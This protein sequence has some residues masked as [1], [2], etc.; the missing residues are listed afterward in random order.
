MKQFSELGLAEPI[1]RAVSGEGYTNPT[2]IQAE[3]IP[4]L[5]G[6]QDLIGIA[7]T[8]TGKT[9]AYVLPLLNTI[10]ADKRRAAPKSCKALILVPTRE[11]AKQV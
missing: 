2:P 5:L 10:L 3:V 1:L 6:G 7:Q 11:L 9:A 8:G 4:A